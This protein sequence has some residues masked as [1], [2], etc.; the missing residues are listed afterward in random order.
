MIELAPRN[1][2]NEPVTLGTPAECG[3]REQEIKGDQGQHMP[4]HALKI[5][6]FSMLPGDVK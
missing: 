3:K 5:K 2:R 4:F 1:E 6:L